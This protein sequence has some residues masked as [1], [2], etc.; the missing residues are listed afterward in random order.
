MTTS[1]KG[2]T[3]PD[4]A[5]QTGTSLAGI[6]YLFA[7]RY[8]GYTLGTFFGGR[9]F[10]RVR[11]HP[12][13]AINLIVMSVLT[14]LVP[15]TVRIWP[16]LAIMLVLGLA[17]GTMDVGGNTILIWA[18]GNKVGP[19][20]NGMHFFFGVGSLI[21]P[22]IVAR[23]LLIWDDFRPAYWLVAG[24][25]LPVS[26]LLLRFPSPAP[27]ENRDNKTNERNTASMA[28]GW[29]LMGLFTLFFFLYT[30]SE[31]TFG[32]WIYTYALA[33]GM[34]DEQL[35]A[36]LTSGFFGAFTIGRLLAI[37]IAARIGSIKILL[38]DMLMCLISIVIILLIP[39]SIVI[40]F[41]ATFGVG[42]SMA[43]VFPTMLSFA[44][45]RMQIT[46]RTSG[47]LFAGANIGVMILPWIAGLL[48]EP[49]GPAVVMYVILGACMMGMGVLI[50]L[51]KKTGF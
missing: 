14:A 47:W 19:I 28:P 51:D 32:G 39:N 50:A 5:H 6:S 20:M 42:L 3:L 1:L 46:G 36:F 16:F 30:G 18:H 2:P 37:P 13:I 45:E 10:D 12:L 25:V 29:L 11:G 44:G 23:C 43:S 24:F 7:V 41:L 21:S 48:F 22:I 4:L 26:F 38:A 31:G 9:L 15:L 33:T 49:V 40:L 17:E 8:L 27:Q 34:A 35:A